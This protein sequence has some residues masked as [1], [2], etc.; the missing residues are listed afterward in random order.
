MLLD[1]F[2][3]SEPGKPGKPGKTLVSFSFSFFSY[4]LAVL[5][6]VHKMFQDS[7]NSRLRFSLIFSRHLYRQVPIM[8]PLSNQ[9][10]HP[11]PKSPSTIVQSCVYAAEFSRNRKP[12]NTELFGE[13]KIRKSQNAF[14][15]VE[16]Y[17]D[18]G[19]CT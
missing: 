5:R 4:F 3:R 14:P 11:V 2:A 9:S 16:M 15:Y 12:A 10:C 6:Y 1:V 8:Y 18:L 19:F 17:S 7:C 13:S